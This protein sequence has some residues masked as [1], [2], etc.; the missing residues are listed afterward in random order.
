MTIEDNTVNA[1]FICFSLD[2]ALRVSKTF[3]TM[4]KLKVIQDFIQGYCISFC[5]LSLTSECS[6]GS[7][8]TR[9]NVMLIKL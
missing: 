9:L 5:R 2:C 8:Q 3:S 6:E 4:F 1:F 7:W